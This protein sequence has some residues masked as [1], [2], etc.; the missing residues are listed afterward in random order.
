MS[1]AQ[2]LNFIVEINSDWEVSTTVNVPNQLLLY[3]TITSGTYTLAWRGTTAAQT[4][5]ALAYNASASS[6]QTA[7]ESRV[8]IGGGNVVVS[9]SSS[10]Y[11]LT[12]ANTLGL[13]IPTYLTAAWTATT[14]N[15]QIAPIPLDL[16]GYD[17][18]LGAKD[19][20]GNVLASLTTTD[21]PGTGKITLG[22]TNGLL[23]WIVYRAKT[24]TWAPA[25]GTA[26]YDLQ[27][28]LPTSGYH[29]PLG[30]GALNILR[31]AL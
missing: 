11:T 31:S 22:T 23:S 27:L 15:V 1:L 5:S 14:G 19:T 24:A 6:I 18:I 17:A 20:N 30:R 2:T 3:I 8:G 7:L 25:S 28:I 4:T 12:F 13:V 21:V 26:Y 9:G 16:T 29:A 10:P